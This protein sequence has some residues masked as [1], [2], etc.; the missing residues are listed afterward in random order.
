MS[1]VPAGTAIKSAPAVRW[2]REQA[3]PLWLAHGVDWG[4]GAFHEHLREG[5]L[6]CSAD[7]RRLR[8]AA[9]QTYVF[10]KA[11]QLGVPRAREAVELGLAFLRGPARLPD[12]GFAWRFDLANQPIDRTRD[13]YDHA[14]VLLAF[15]AAAPVVGPDMLRGDARAVLDYIAEKLPHPHGGYEESV[16]PTRPRRQNPHMHLLEALLAAHDSF[17]GTIY[18][19]RAHDLIALF[20]A[21]LFQPEEG[22]LPE[23]LDEQLKPLREPNGHYVIEPG[24]LYEWIWLLH[25]YRKSALMRA[26]AAKPELDAASAALLHFVDRFAL[27][28]ATGL[29]VNELWSDGSVRSGAFRLWP[30]TERLKAEVRR[31]READERIA[32]AFAALVRHLEGVQPP[33]L[34]RERINPDGSSVSEPTPATSLYH[35]TAAL[36]DPA[37]TAFS[38]RR[39]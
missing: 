22:A 17:G 14:F 26:Q 2:L 4:A 29:V 20:L 34:W 11:A 32:A 23:Y 27:D 24:H 18:L 3:W 36:T 15:A 1:A 13:L 37:V 28:P 16:P 6:D 10:A 5:A 19:E 39:E 31:P 8:V 33:G 12:G 7:F 21:R 38:D 30:Q 9:R 35:L 25:W